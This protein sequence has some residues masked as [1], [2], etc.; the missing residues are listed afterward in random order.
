LQKAH[1]FLTSNTMVCLK[2]V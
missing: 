2:M 1:R